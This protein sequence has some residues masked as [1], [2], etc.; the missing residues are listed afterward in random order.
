MTRQSEVQLVRDV[1]CVGLMRREREK[2]SGWGFVFVRSQVR[3]RNSRND[4]D[5]ISHMDNEKKNIEGPGEST[6]AY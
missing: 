2:G 6:V 5:L 1:V 3:V 4:G